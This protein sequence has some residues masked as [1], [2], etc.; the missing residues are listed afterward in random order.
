MSSP[1]QK[2]TRS[3]SPMP[4]PRTELIRESGE[5]G[6]ASTHWDQTKNRSSYTASRRWGTRTQ[7][8][9]RGENKNGN[10]GKKPYNPFTIYAEYNAKHNTGKSYCGY[11]YHST[12]IAKRGT[13]LVFNEAKQKFQAMQTDNK[14]EWGDVR[15]ILFWFKKTI[16][17]QYRNMMWH[18]LNTECEKCQFWDDVYRKHIAQVNNEPAVPIQELTDEEM[19]QAAIEMDGASE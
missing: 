19:L 8:S 5:K 7:N 16:D 10:K 11:Y 1:R 4:R 18:F 13:D 3:P 17:Q 2:R 14:V 9:G 6:S 12:R 15:E